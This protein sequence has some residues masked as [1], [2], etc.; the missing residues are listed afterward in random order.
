[1]E[2]TL[3]ETVGKKIQNKFF[4]LEKVTTTYFRIFMLVS[5]KIKKDQTPLDCY[6]SPKGH[7]GIVRPYIR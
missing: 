4:I 6:H 2:F 1:M 3:D 5:L 7:F